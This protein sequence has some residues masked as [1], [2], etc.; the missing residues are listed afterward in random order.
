MKETKMKPDWRKKRVMIIP[1]KCYKK[2]SR[3][4]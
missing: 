1:E 2:A 3:T 4:V